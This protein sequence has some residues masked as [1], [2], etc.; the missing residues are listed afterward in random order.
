MKICILLGGASPERNVSLSSGT[1]IGETLKAL[2]HRILYLDPATPL[3]EMETFRESLGHISMENMDF[4]GMAALRDHYFIEHIPY[5]EKEAVDLVFNALHGGNGENGVIAALLEMAGI[6]FTGSGY[7][8]SALAMDKYRSKLL[9]A[10]AGVLSADFEIHR[11]PVQRPDRLAFSLVVKPNDA[12]STVGLS[13]FHEPADLTGACRKALAFSDAFIIE[14][15][16]PGREFNIP[17]VAGEVYRSWKWTPAGS[18]ISMPNIW[19]TTRNTWSR[20]PSRGGDG[21]HAGPGAPDVPHTGTPELRRVDFRMTPEGE[22]YLLEANS[23][24]GMTASSL[25]PKSAKAAGV[26]FSRLLQIIIED[27]L[28]CS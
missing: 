16:I 7:A 9:A 15:Y 6:P 22:I 24:P 12:G 5:L 27:A 14:S 1:A 20:P 26:G 23:L 21:R 25:V 8:A 19:A 17:V 18:M 10:E 3:K 28:R 13:I 2:G 4:E 11:K